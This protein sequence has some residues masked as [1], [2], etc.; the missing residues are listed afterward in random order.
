MK[1][2]VADKKAPITAVAWNYA[3][4]NFAVRIFTVQ[5]NVLVELV[6]ER[7]RGGWSQNPV[8]TAETVLSS[9]SPD[10]LSS[11]AATGLDENGK[12]TVFYQPSRQVIAQYDSAAKRVPLGIS[13]AR[14]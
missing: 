10:Q 4:N 12:L 11:A 7:G 1:V 2:W 14:D 5:S 3:S 6:F 8:S 13:T 9:A